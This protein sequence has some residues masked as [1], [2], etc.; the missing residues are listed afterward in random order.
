M[1]EDLFKALNTGQIFTFKH[2][3]LEARPPVSFIFIN[4]YTPV[5]GEAGQQ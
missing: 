1:N 4:Q 3:F 2:I 5:E